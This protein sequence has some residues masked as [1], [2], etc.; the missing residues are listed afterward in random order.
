VLLQQAGWEWIASQPHA[1]AHKHLRNWAWTDALD[2]LHLVILMLPTHSY[3][4]DGI[5]P[6][7]GNHGTIF[8]S[9][10]HLLQASQPMLSAMDGCLLCVCCWFSSSGN[11]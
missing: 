1:S 2:Y 5:I 6:C 4:P 10:K 11:L 7:F 3:N 9:C 8:E